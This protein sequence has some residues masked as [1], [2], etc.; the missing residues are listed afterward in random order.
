MIKRI[1][2]EGLV[3]G[4]FILFIG[5]AII[6]N[7]NGHFVKTNIQFNNN[8]VNAYWEFDECSGDIAYDSSGNGYDGTIYGASWVGGF[9][10]CGL[11]FD[12]VDDYV[13]FDDHAKYYLGFNS[14]D[15][16]IFSF[17]FKS[18]STQRGMIYSQCRGDD[19]GLLPGVNIALAANGTIEFQ[20]WMLGCGILMWS[21]GIYNDGSWHY[22]EIY[23]NGHAETRKQ[24]STG[25]IYVDGSFEGIF[26]YEVC[27]FWDDQFRYAQ[28]GRDS[29]ES[30]DYF[31]GVIDEFK[32]IEYSGGNKQVP[33][34][35]DG[36]TSGDP[37]VEYNY[38]FVTNDPEDDDIGLEIDWGNGD[39]WEL[40]GPYASGEEVVVGYTYNE[41]GTYEIKARSEDFWRHSEWSEPYGV[42]IG[43]DP[44]NAPTI[45]GPTHGNPNEP[46]TFTFHAADPDNDMVRYHVDWGDG[47]QET[48]NFD[49]IPLDIS[50]TYTAS[51]RYTITA[52]A[53][54]SPGNI[55]PE[56]TFLFVCPRDKAIN[57]MLFQNLLERFPFL[58]KLI[59]QLSFGK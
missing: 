6:P 19:Y 22:V 58:Q 10:G 32:I 11:D 56:G 49:Y 2:K 34:T 39:I 8:Y 30:D 48:T 17:Y 42:K 27:A 31:D 24:N 7:I 3:L 15:D 43:N 59:Q 1:F 40:P 36:P 21:E 50:H 28:M 25:T 35:I 41:K 12:G 14:T 54:D 29:N 9:S 47:T 45:T 57:N 37:G 16:V 13:N 51:G 23:Y 38:T 5:A 4:I 55:G 33:P 52:Y 46:Q 18:T 20:V 26:L 53:E 44:P